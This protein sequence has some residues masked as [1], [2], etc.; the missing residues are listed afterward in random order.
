M[1]SG[2][3]VTWYA[4]KAYSVVQQAITLC[5]NAYG[6]LGMHMP[7]PENMACADLFAPD[8]FSAED[9]YGRSAPPDPVAESAQNLLQNMLNMLQDLQRK[10]EATENVFRQYSDTG[11]I[12]L[13][14]IRFAEHLDSLKCTLSDITTS[15]DKL[16]K[17]SEDVFAVIPNTQSIRDLLP[18]LD[19]C[20]SGT[21][22]LLA[23]LTL[24]QGIFL[25]SETP[26]SSITDQIRRHSGSD[27]RAANAYPDPPSG[28]EELSSS[29]SSGSSARTESGSNDPSP[30]QPPVIPPPELP[31]HQP[32]VISSAPSGGRFSS[33]FSKLFSKSNRR[34]SNPLPDI[35]PAASAPPQP[36]PA[37][38]PSHAASAVFSTPADD[39]IAQLEHQYRT[40][41]AA[42]IPKN[43]PPA[44]TLDQFHISAVTPR[45]VSAGNY[46]IVDVVL[47]EDA[48][49]G[50][51]DQVLAEQEHGGKETLGG[52]HAA[53]KGTPILVALSSPDVT[54]DEP[55]ETQVWQGKY[56]R[57]SFDFAVPEEYTKRQVLLRAAV[58]FA[59]VPATRLRIL[60][61]L[62]APAGQQPAIERCDIRSAFMSY[63]TV[64]REKVIRIMQGIQQ[65]RP[66]L[67]LFLDVDS[68][69]SGENWKA[70]LYA[71][72]DR[73]DVLYLCWSRAA[74]DSQYVTMEWQYALRRKGIDGIEPI[75]LEPAENCPPPSD[76][77]QLHFGNRLLFIIRN[78]EA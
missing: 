69:H 76:L 15:S 58:Y 56:L 31:S 78:P 28:S 71:E 10:L 62:A 11:R 63:A 55:E 40:G 5:E 52:A 8:D 35:P 60:I 53:A 66:D 61:N 24:Y 44:P 16:T 64:E 9:T 49:R 70:R 30:P 19:K 54:I 17:L 12:P 68:L 22:A 18:C 21:M 7:D 13:D 72:I 3:N 37:P 46:G 38:P 41:N 47:Y 23:L 1:R 27:N 74:R 34:N 25:Q 36:A 77:D 43:P 50:V 65:V 4:T 42:P 57:F 59:D 6:E 2:V 26:E 32:P 14:A 51:I 20:R 45:S 75:P 33:I 29:A 67:D 48:F 73:R 39:A